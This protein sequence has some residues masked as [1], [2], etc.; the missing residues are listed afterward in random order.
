MLI[1]VRNSFSYIKSVK[2]NTS[3]KPPKISKVFP[4]L[5]SLNLVKIK[6]KP[7]KIIKGAIIYKISSENP[8]L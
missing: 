8:M 1:I 5:F 2:L 7:A 4:N 3:N 6:I